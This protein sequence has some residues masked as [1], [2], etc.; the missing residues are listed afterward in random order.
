MS[1]KPKERAEAG[2]KAKAEAKAENVL[3]VAHHKEHARLRGLFPHAKIVAPGA[4]ICG[5]GADLILIDDPC[6]SPQ[7][8]GNPNRDRVMA[9]K[10]HRWYAEALHCRL[11]P[12]ARMGIM[13]DIDPHVLPALVRDPTKVNGS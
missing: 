10:L 13:H 3:I 1:E 5:Y 7:L 4:G 6:L 9:D 12:E 11:L 2:V 8:T